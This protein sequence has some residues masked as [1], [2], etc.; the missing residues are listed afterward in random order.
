MTCH[1]TKEVIKQ[2]T[3]FSSP[4]LAFLLT[5]TI[6]LSFWIITTFASLIRYESINELQL[7]KEEERECK[8]KP[9][10][11]NK[12]Q[13]IKKR[14]WF[15]KSFMNRGCQKHPLTH[16]VTLRW[17][18]QQRSVRCEASLEFMPWLKEGLFLGSLVVSQMQIWTK[19]ENFNF[20]Q[21][22]RSWV[23]TEYQPKTRWWRMKAEPRLWVVRLLDV[24]CSMCYSP[25]QRGGEI[26]KNKTVRNS[27]SQLDPWL[28]LG[29]IPCTN[30]PNQGP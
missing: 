26:Q 7:G 14:S 15:W 29:Q 20:N 9:Q 22:T 8:K 18:K 10:N 23:C 2:P 21:I 19:F 17:G 5:I 16:K 11:N 24:S 28:P 25:E 3:K 1:F 6:D 12:T 13:L 4:S 30:A 27:D